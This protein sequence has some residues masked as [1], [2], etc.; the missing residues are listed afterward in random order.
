MRLWLQCWAIL[1]LCLFPICVSC[2][3]S[4][5]EERSATFDSESTSEIAYTNRSITDR[6][7]QWPEWETWQRVILLRDYNTRI[8]IFGTTLLGLAAGVIGSFTLLRKRALMGDALSHATLPGIGLAFIFATNIG[9]EGKALPVLLFGA[10]ITGLLGMVSILVIRNLTRLKED[11]ALGIV[12]SVFFGGGVAVLGIVQQMPSG[13]AAGL[14]GFIYG[15]TASMVATDAWLIGIAGAACLLIALLFFKELKLLCFDD[16]YAGARGFPVTA[17]DLLLMALV[18]VITIVGLQAVGLILMIALL[19]IPA[20]AARFWTQQMTRMTAYSAGIGAVSCMLGAGMSAILPKLPSG[21]MIVLTSAFFFLVSMFFGTSRGVTIR[22][23]RRWQLNRKI[24]RQHLLRGLYEYLEENNLL[25]ANRQNPV[26]WDEVFSM[27]SWSR[28]RLAGCINRAADDGLVTFDPRRWVRLTDAGFIRAE[29]L[30]HDHRLWEMYL[31]THAD[32][33]PSRVDRD[34]DAIEHV[35]DAELIAR[36]EE[37][38]NRSR[39]QDGMPANPHA[40]GEIL[41]STDMTPSVSKSSTVSHESD[42]GNQ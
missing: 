8:V 19:V 39:R 36:L 29:H 27:R 22:A 1:L 26:P 5:D 3:S 30:V 33:A 6:G 18:T 31:I 35:L 20:A 32:V 23:T 21:A 37:L 24:D 7:V 28:R 40:G 16:G 2:N 15:K 14:E 42:S 4:S 11:A 34:A 41:E 13:H 12:L 9:F 38:L 17:L 10:L 25:A